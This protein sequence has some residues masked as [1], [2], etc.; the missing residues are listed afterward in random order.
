MADESDNA[1]TIAAW[2][3]LAVAD[4]IGVATMVIVLYEYVVTFHMEVDLFWGKEITGASIVF[5]LNRYLVL[6]YY[7]VQLPTWFSLS[8]S[9]CPVPQ[10]FDIVSRGSL[11]AADLIVAV[12]TFVTTYK[13]A[14]MTR[15]VLKGRRN[16]SFAYLLLRDGMMYFIVLLVMNVIHLSFSLASVLVANFDDGNASDISKFNESLTAILIWRFMLNLQWAR[17][18]TEEVSSQS[19]NTSSLN[20]DR[21]VGSIGESL[22]SKIARGHLDIGDE[23]SAR[24]SELTPAGNSNDSMGTG[25]I[26]PT[27]DS[28]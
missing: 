27:V 22:G 4:Y 28:N 23:D 13:S 18:Q 19:Q 1:A 24:P 10:C 12:V 2:N 26:L 3:A 11:I 8:G 14:I 7:L 16:R 17:Q 15:K 9:L 20:F 21:V 5:F 6:A 25:P